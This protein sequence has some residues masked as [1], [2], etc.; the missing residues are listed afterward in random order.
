MARKTN[1]TAHVLNLIAGSGNENS[2]NDAIDETKDATAKPGAEDNALSNDSASVKNTSSSNFEKTSKIN[3]PNKAGNSPNLEILFND[4]DPLS[5]L[6]KD[7]LE[8]IEDMNTPDE[9]STQ[10]ELPVED[11]DISNENS[12]ADDGEKPSL[13]DEETDIS[14]SMAHENKIQENK[15]SSDDVETLP[16]VT[17]HEN[18]IIPDDNLNVEQHAPKSTLLEEIEKSSRVHSHDRKN[19]NSMLDLDFKYVNVYERIVQDKILEYMDKFDM[20]KCDR[21]IIDTF[22][23]ALTFL[24][25]KIVVVDRDSSFPMISFYETKNTAIISTSLI[26]ACVM[27]KDKPNH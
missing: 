20:C 4:H 9:L 16:G 17:D 22:A 8:D 12:P 10:E 7:A 23:L 11:G 1:K 6:I 14:D 24:P 19:L 3:E 25:T 5:D 15:E 2:S 27:V 21:C 26:R 18:I 13:P